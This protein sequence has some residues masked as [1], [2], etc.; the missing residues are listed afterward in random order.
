M[1][2]GN[3]W[4]EDIALDTLPVFSNGSYDPSDAGVPIGLNEADMIAELENAAKVLGL[5]IYGAY[6]VPAIKD[7]YISNLST[8]SGYF[9]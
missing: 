5:E 7:D 3:L 6:Y 2:N 1:E 9:N 4:R 8:Y